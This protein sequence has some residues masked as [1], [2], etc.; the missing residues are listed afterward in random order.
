MLSTCL[1]STSRLDSNDSTLLIHSGLVA[2][3]A[4]FPVGITDLLFWDWVSVY[5]SGGPLT[6]ASWGWDCRHGPPC[7]TCLYCKE[8]DAETQEKV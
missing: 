3:P 7:P 1:N 8:E 2:A 5:S 4:L 6:S